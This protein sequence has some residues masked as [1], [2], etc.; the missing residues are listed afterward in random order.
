[1]AIVVITEGKAG[2][3]LQGTLQRLKKE[4]GIKFIRAD[5]GSARS[6]EYNVE[7]IIEAIKSTKSQGFLHDGCWA[8]WREAQ[9]FPNVRRNDNICSW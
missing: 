2:T 4:R 7:H 6:F 5:T 1:M 3:K 9:H 8:F